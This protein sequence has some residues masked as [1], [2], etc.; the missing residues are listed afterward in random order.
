LENVANIDRQQI[1]KFLY[2]IAW[3]IEI[4]AASVG[5]FLAIAQIIDSSGDAFN[6]V[7]AGIP[8]FAVA[9]VE[10]TKIPL[11]S[12][13]YVTENL[14]WKLIFAVALGLAMIIT[15]ETFFVGFERYQAVL[16][17]SI[18]T[19]KNDINDEQRIID[20]ADKREDFAE[21]K[22]NELTINNKSYTAEVESINNRI[23]KLNSEF[24]RRI[25]VINDK[26]KNEG[27]KKEIDR[28]TEQ[29]NSIEGKRDK[30]ILI[31]QNNSDK[32]V[33]ELNKKYFQY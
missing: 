10:L 32:S 23:D 33:K 19:L 4:I 29:I 6:S 20:I 17:K 28:L 7:L 14:K 1:S 27:L 15:F 2:R 18:Q 3:A 30:E 16:T 12:V 13:F 5:L 11:A 31:I 8:F 26:Y 21:E 24:E 25:N 9:I 22:Q